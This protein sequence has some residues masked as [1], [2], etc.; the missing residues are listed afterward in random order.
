MFWLKLADVSFVVLHILLILFVVF[1][2]IPKRTRKLH[3]L[4]VILVALSWFVLGIFFG[5]GYCPLTDLQW[6]IKL[7]LQEEEL[8]FSFIKYLLDNITG[9]NFNE[10]LIDYVTLFIF[11][12]VFIISTYL[13][14]PYIKK[15]FKK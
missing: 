3:F 9:Y 8:P 6:N 12:S 7:K 11:V 4:V 1:G 2:W 5:F 14:I 13:N 15:Q 10:T